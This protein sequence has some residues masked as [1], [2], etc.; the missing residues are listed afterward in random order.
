MPTKP[1][2]LPDL[3]VTRRL[4]LRRHTLD[5]APLIFGVVDA[6][7]ERLA[8][9]LPWV[10]SMRSVEDERTFIKNSR[11]DW[12]EGRTFDYG[13]YDGNSNEFLGTI[14]IHTIRWD[15]DCAE[16]GFWIARKFEGK[17][18][19]SEA[20]LA[21]EEELCTVGFHRIEIRCDIRN[22]R[23]AAVAKRCGYTLDGVLRQNIHER[24]RYN[25]TMV[26]GKLI[27]RLER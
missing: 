22:Q 17:G 15:H 19:V 11:R 25:D 3:L 23:S 21:M 8:A 10:P 26:W 5:L 14:G 9:F 6:E 18:V 4:A 2:L 24:G 1:T 7:R 20:V 16:L 27:R 13:I 12:D